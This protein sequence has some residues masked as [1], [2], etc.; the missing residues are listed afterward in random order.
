MNH[1]TFYW[2]EGKVVMTGSGQTTFCVIVKRRYVEGSQETH[3]LS[4]LFLEHT[5]TNIR[6]TDVVA[7]WFTNNLL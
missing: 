7:A 4:I 1:I 2:F 5:Y 6:I 3:N